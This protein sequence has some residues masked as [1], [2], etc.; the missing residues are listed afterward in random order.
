M[1]S[2]HSCINFRDIGGVPSELGFVARGR[3]YRTAQ[4]SGVDDDSAEHLARTLRIARY[5]DF[6]GQSEIE[7]DGEPRLLLERGVHWVRNPFDLS[8]EIFSSVS[9]PAASDWQELYVRAVRRLRPELVQAIRHIAEAD[10]P[11]VFGCWVGKDRTG[12]VAALLLSLLGVKDEVIAEDFAKTTELLAPFRAQYTVLW[13]LEPHAAE[14]I[15]NC[16]SVASAQTMLGFLAAVRSE[17]GSA[18]AALA[19]DQATVDALR[20]RYLVEQDDA[21]EPGPA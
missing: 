12:V 4:L 3:L 21:L 2:V 6:R 19:L 13:Q 10:A 20:A 1:G 14:E 7:R 5:I 16:Y 8:D 9:R 18:Q 17:F 11:V 15:F